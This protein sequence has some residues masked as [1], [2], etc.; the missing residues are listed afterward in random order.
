MLINLLSYKYIY[1]HLPLLI[2][3]YSIFGKEKWNWEK[4]WWDK[5]LPKAKNGEIEERSRFLSV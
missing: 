2:S 1:S 4:L 5:D 3:L